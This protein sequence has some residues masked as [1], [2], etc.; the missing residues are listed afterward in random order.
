MQAPGGCEEGINDTFNVA[1][2]ER[3][4]QIMKVLLQNRAVIISDEWL[5]PSYIIKNLL[6]DT[7][8]CAQLEHAAGKLMRTIP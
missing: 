1:A 7:D 3:H 4:V 2:E 8:Y 6:Q 5:T